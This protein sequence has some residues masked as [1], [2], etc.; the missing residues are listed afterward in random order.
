MLA[1]H[2][3][4]Q[5]RRNISSALAAT[6]PRHTACGMRPAAA[7]WLAPLRSATR[8]EWLFLSAQ[9]GLVAGIELSDDAAHAV[10][11]PVNAA[12]GLAN[13]VHVMDF[14]R[15]HGVWL[16]PGIQ[17]FFASTH[18]MLGRTVGWAQ[19]RPI[20]D[21][22]YGEGHVFFTLAFA[23][24]VFFWRRSLFALIRNVF[25]LTNVLAVVLYETFPLAPPRLA[26]QP[27]ARAQHRCAPFASGCS[28]RA[29]AMR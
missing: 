9:I 12:A 27:S 26:S 28:M 14:E 1:A 7:H 24:W 6:N 10:L 20:V 5:R 22:L 15:A 2:A 4:P 8:R 29:A 16:E 23:L 21:A 11:P 18:S 13:A 25:V 19:V 3:Q 17:R